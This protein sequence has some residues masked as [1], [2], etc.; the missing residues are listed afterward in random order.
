MSPHP[1]GCVKVHEDRRVGVSAEKIQTNKQRLFFKT[2]I[3]EGTLLMGV[4]FFFVSW[5][6]MV[7]Y[8]GRTLW[9]LF[10]FCSATVFFIVSFNDACIKLL[11]GLVV[12]RAAHTALYKSPI[13]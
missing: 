5:S 11:L 12:G 10:A 9:G 1:L 6:F 8:W 3:C 2:D 4:F 7:L 13:V